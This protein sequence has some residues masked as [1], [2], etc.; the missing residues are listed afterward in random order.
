M[1]QIIF[2]LCAETDATEAIE[3]DT[4]GESQT[5]QETAADLL[6]MTAADSAIDPLEIQTL[7]VKASQ[8]AS[9]KIGFPHPYLRNSSTSVT[10]VQHVMN[11][12]SQTQ[13]SHHFK[14]L[15]DSLQDHLPTVTQKA[16]QRNH[17]CQN[18]SQ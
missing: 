12:H 5:D 9:V 1:A 18:T 13:I 10:Q 2:Q 15:P 4:V 16:K 8:P 6:A 14:T 3:K 11:C 7:T 17:T